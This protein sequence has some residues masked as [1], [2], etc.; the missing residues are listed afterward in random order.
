MKFNPIT[1]D[2][3]TDEHEL[4]KK[5][6][7]P[8]NVKWSELHGNET[9]RQ[10]TKCNHSVIN[11]KGLTDKFLLKMVKDNPNTCLRVGFDQ[12]NIQI[13]TDAQIL[14]KR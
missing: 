11:T 14:E 3:F 5:L 1:K 10:C 13:T 7:C 9:S 8:F 4:I 12:S 2:L 6:H